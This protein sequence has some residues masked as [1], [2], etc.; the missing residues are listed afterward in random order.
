MREWRERKISLF[1]TRWLGYTL[2]FRWLFD[3]ISRYGSWSLKK[4]LWDIMMMRGHDLILSSNDP[5][6]DVKR[7]SCVCMLSLS[8]DLDNLHSL[9]KL[10]I[11]I[12][13]SSKLIGLELIIRLYQIQSS[14]SIFSSR[15]EKKVI[16]R[17]KEFIVIIL[18][19]E[20]FC[21]HSF[22]TFCF[23][24]LIWCLSRSRMMTNDGIF[25]LLIYFFL[26]S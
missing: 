13:S 18:R 26:R 19:K 5:H 3:M 17:R 15:C 2:W 23:Y 22:I 4:D 1:I 9:M 16:K 20:N 24:S 7:S 10:M 6:Q 14:L 12:L 25:C 8:C 21:F 11:I